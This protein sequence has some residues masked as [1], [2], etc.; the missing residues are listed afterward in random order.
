MAGTF[1]CTDCQ[2]NHNNSEK[3]IIKFKDEAD[4]GAAGRDRRSGNHEE[5]DQIRCC[6]C[7]VAKS[8]ISRLVKAE[9]W[10]AEFKDMSTEGRAKLMQ[11]AHELYGSDLSKL[12]KM[13]VTQSSSS[14]RVQQ[15]KKH[16]GF[17]DLEDLSEKYKNKPLQLAAIAGLPRPEMHSVPGPRV[18]LE[19]RDDAG[20]GAGLQTSGRSRVQRE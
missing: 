14:S 10:G 17:V 7:H 11:D 5:G 6:K 19:G 20:N 15:F 3:Y 9:G 16:G 12:V 1:F 18:Q 8:R 4:L 13:T 2:L